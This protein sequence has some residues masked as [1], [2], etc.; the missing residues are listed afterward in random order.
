MS[1]D[2]TPPFK[3][4]PNGE[5]WRIRS[6]TVNTEWDTDVSSRRVVGLFLSGVRALYRIEGAQEETIEALHPP[7][8]L[9]PMRTFEVE[10]DPLYESTSK[11]T[12]PNLVAADVAI[13]MNP[14]EVRELEALLYRVTRRIKKEAGLE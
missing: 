12:K 1:E 8:H 13:E 7:V 10:V 4:D 9:Y 5:L 3:R 6:I 14:Q 2:Y 11:L